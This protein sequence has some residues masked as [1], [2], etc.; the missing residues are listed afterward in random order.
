MHRGFQKTYHWF[1]DHIRANVFNIYNRK[2]LN[3]KPRI[4]VTGISYGAA[5]A[6]I[7]A[8]DLKL[9]GKSKKIELDI[10]S[11]TFGQPRIGNQ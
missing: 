3:P 6:A 8:Y 1:K 9:Y 11:Y 10:I 7:A 2:E 4:V 5:I